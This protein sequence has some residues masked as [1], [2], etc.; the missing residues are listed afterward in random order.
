MAK[1]SHRAANLR[2]DVEQ[3]PNGPCLR[4]PKALDCPAANFVESKST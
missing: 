1:I 2:R 3:F 4:T